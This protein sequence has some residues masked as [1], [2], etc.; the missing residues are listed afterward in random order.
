MKMKKR[1]KRRGKLPSVTTMDRHHICF[2]KRYWNKGYAKAICT[3]FVRY[4]PVVYHRELHVI[5]NTVPVPDQVLLKEAWNNYQ[6][7]RKTIDAYDVTR[8]AAWLYVN[9]P[10]EKF[11][12]AMQLQIDFFTT[13]SSRSG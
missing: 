12:K 9:I 1:K 10:D 11:R 7:E 2:Q 5:L 8:A 13:K 6:K 3:A 4:V